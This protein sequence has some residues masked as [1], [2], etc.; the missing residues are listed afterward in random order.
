MKHYTN[1]E[2]DS[3]ITNFLNKKLDKYP[4]LAMVHQDKPVN[5]DHTFTTRMIHSLTSRTTLSLN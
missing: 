2:L 5:S 1:E 3:K 4:E